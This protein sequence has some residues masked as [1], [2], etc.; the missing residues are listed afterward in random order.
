ME[1]ICLEHRKDDDLEIIPLINV[2]HIKVER[3]FFD[4]DLE[5]YYDKWTV[6]LLL[7][8][9]EKIEVEVDRESSNQLIELLSI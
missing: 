3:G 7:D 4:G 6:Y 9:R 5:K 8:G 1:N 2:N